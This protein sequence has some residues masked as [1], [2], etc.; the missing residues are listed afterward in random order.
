MGGCADGSYSGERSV[1][2]K[3]EIELEIDAELWQRGAM[4]S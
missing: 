1:V 2:A 4:R 3:S